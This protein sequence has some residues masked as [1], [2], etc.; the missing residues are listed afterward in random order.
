MTQSRLHPRLE[1]VRRNRKLE[2]LTE[3]VIA[4]VIILTVFISLLV[5]GNSKYNQNR[6]L[7]Y[8]LDKNC[9]VNELHDTIGAGFT[10]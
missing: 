9:N 10:K 7:G 5:S 6:C 8:G 2:H 3:T 4:F 1:R